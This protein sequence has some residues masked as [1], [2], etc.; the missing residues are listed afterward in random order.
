MQA[1]N[2]WGKMIGFALWFG[3]AFALFAAWFMSLISGEDFG[4]VLRSVFLM[5]FVW[6]AVISILSGLQYRPIT[7]SVSCQDKTNFLSRLK[8]IL[9]EMGWNLSLNAESS[10]VFKHP[11]ILTDTF[12]GRISVFIKHASAELVGSSAVLKALQKRL[13]SSNQPSHN[14][15]VDQSPKGMRSFCTQCG[16]RLQVGDKFCTSCGQSV[17]T[18]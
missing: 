16:E 1:S 18:A 7:I 10:L 9:A 15:V 13:N 11:N 6:G 12:Q 4:G 3:L 17:S 5:W 8:L 2:Y 14:E